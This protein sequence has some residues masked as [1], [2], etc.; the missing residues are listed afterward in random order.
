[1]KQRIITAFFLVAILVPIVIIGGWLF[2]IT[3]GIGV[4]IATFEML[5][6]FDHSEEKVKKSVKIASVILAMGTYSMQTYLWKTN[7]IQDFN[8]GVYPLCISYLFIQNVVL[9]SMFVFD[10][11]VSINNIMR[12]LF[13]INYVAFGF[14]ALSFLRGLGVRFIIYLLIATAATDAFAYLFGVK[15]GK[16]KMCPSISP[17]KSWEGA[18]AGTVFGTVLATL[19]AFFYGNLFKGKPWNEFDNMTLLENFCS[20]G[21]NQD[22]V[23]FIVIFVL[24]FI[25]SVL[26]Q[27]GDLVASKLKRTYNIKDYGKI[28]PGHGG[29]LDRFDSAIFVSMILVGLFILLRILFP[30]PYLPQP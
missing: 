1:M 13:M 15:F 19:F 10:S 16:H 22:F 26:G 17:K 20:L 5:S 18:I 2:Y 3:V 14:S 8:F 29:V 11:K 25:A 9:L 4:G 24:S 28:F 6:M 30:I 21:E 23:Q 27:V 12:V 7:E